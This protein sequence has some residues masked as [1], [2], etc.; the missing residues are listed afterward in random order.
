MLY[1]I[2]YN[3]D[4][5]STDIEAKNHMDAFLKSARQSLGKEALKGARP[6]EVINGSPR[7]FQVYDGKELKF[8]ELYK[9]NDL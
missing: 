2:T 1:H 3:G 8:F 5:K 9:S 6:M 4:G 7:S